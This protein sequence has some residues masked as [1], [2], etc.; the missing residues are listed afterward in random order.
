MIQF[1]FADVRWFFGV[2]ESLEDPDQLGRVQVRCFG[3][4]TE[5]KEKSDFKGIPTDDLHWAQVAGSP[6]GGRMHGMSQGPHKLVNGTLVAGVFMDGQRAQLPVV[7]FTMGTKTP[8]DKPNPAKGFSDPSGT[9]PED[10]KLDTPHLNELAR[11]NWGEHPINEQ[12]D[13]QRTDWEPPQTLEPEYPFN[14]VYQ[15]T[16]GHII[17]LDDSPG[18][19]RIRLIHRTG[20][21][22]EIKDDGRVVFKS[23][24]DK[25]EITDGDKYREVTGDHFKM[26]R[27]DVQEEIKGDR[28]TLLHG[29]STEEIRSD[30]DTLLHGT[31]TEEIKGDRDTLLHGTSTEEI[32]SDRDTLL[33]G[34]STEEIKGDK[35][36]LM[37][38]DSFEEVR[39]DK[40]ALMQQ[41]S[42]EEVKGE[43]YTHVHGDE[44][45]EIKGHTWYKAPTIDL[46]NGDL[47]PMVLGDKLAA[48]AEQLT[49]WLD[50]HTH[51]GNLGSS[52]SPPM[53]PQQ[54]SSQSEVWKGGN[55]YSKK[56]RTH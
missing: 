48:W 23:V 42:F 6:M 15:T 9:Y 17:E 27:G 21:Y 29:T 55:V 35:H 40:H 10:E 46:G 32:R 30:R 19:E 52:T 45:K 7:M 28:D 12:L 16:S 36:A 41:D 13:E 54:P 31:S 8:E 37:Q 5:E 3:I 47:E 33:H 26:N 43:R 50:T 44:T 39:G 2:V 53:Q 14:L 24:N 56:N 11:D 51:I 49:I 4:H 20:S 1:P 34:T 38:Q 22:A 25:Y 18:N